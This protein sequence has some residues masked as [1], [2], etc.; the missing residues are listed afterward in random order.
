MDVAFVVNPENY[1]LTFARNSD[2]DFYLDTCAVY[3]VIATVCAEK[4]KWFHDASIGTYLSTITRDG[5]ATGTRLVA[6]ATDGLEQV[7]QDGLI[8]SGAAAS[9]SRLGVGA[10]GL[11]L[12]WQT[13]I[14]EQRTAL[15]L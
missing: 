5:R 10:W 12:R 7:T 15:R 4:G 13:S 3:S 2:G 11:T 14:G 9:T 6:A 1:K 8:R